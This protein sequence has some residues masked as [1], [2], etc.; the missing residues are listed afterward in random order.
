VS[1]NWLGVLFGQCTKL[2]QEPFFYS[3]APN[4]Y[5]CVLVGLLC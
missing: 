5:V 2:N 1:K 3:S 4:G